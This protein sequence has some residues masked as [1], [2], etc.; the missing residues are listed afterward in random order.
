MYYYTRFPI[1][2]LLRRP[3]SASPTRLLQSVTRKVPRGCSSYR[4][5]S[6]LPRLPLFDAIARHDPGSAA[7]VHS[8]SGRRFA[9]GE[10]LGDVCRA[11]SRLR[12]AA[13][14]EDLG[15]ERVAF[16]V[17]NSYDYVGEQLY[18]SKPP[19][20]SFKASGGPIG[21]LPGFVLAARS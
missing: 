9:Y 3:A 19:P 20:A 13:G 5:A 17:E 6:T 8:A 15:G 1:R 12:D 4:M 16:L 21:P 11:R 14:K 7:V 18:Q 10:L 2:T